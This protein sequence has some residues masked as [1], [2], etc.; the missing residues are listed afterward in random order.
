MEKP[1][2]TDVPIHDLLRRRWSPR[3]FSPRS[4]DDAT[5]HVLFEAARWAPS[6]FN[7]QPWAYVIARKEE[8]EAFAKALDCLVPGN[9]AWA[10]GA[11]VLGFS[12][13]KL[14]F[15]KNGKP[16]RHAWHDVGQATATLTIQATSMGLFVHQMA[17]FD[18]DRVRTTY[19]V[20]A[21]HDPVAGIAIGWGADEASLAPEVREKEAGPR[22][23]RPRTSFLF[24][25]RFGAVR[26]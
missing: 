7:E 25:D 10:E 14:A 20:P 18:P 1:A 22:T 9:R 4:V 8:R 19:E 23:R 13:A 21:T 3:A 5:L 11:A 15:D 26:P 24:G 6:S 17:G 2:A 16:N 12:I